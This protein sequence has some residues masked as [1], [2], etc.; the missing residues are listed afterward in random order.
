[1]SEIQKYVDSFSIENLSRIEID[2]TK[3]KIAELYDVVHT[4]S[5]EIPTYI[6][7]ESEE[8]SKENSV[9]IGDISSHEAHE[10][11]FVE[12]N[13]EQKEPLVESSKKQQSEQK[14]T[15]FEQ[16]KPVDEEEN[17]RKP[18][19]ETSV[20]K[21]EESI[22][23]ESDKSKDEKLIDK[24]ESVDKTN[25]Q[26]VEEE[27]MS[28][29]PEHTSQK[30]E[31]TRTTKVSQTQ[32]SIKKPIEQ[33]LSQKLGKKPVSN[34]ASAIGINER[35]QFIKELFGNNVQLY[36]EAIQQ[37]NELSSFENA[38]KLLE[39][40]YKLDFEHELSQRFLNIVERRYL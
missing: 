38:C 21:E 25:V 28:Q 29:E 26:Q 8:I 10:K 24:E 39:K 2:I 14:E 16:S 18:N 31:A 17:I 15:L 36:T 35:Y 12:Q 32:Q 34:I 40:Q 19:K 22:K 37:L 23:Y 33:D 3:R 6:K 4:M 5:V 1:M 13:H 11:E 30:V 7:S 27:V 9:D 20:Y